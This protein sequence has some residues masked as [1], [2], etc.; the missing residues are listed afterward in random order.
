MTRNR[1]KY[2]TNFLIKTVASSALLWYTIVINGRLR[3]R[4][5]TWKDV[6]FKMARGMLL[7]GVDE[8]ELRP[9]PKPEKPKTP[10]GK[11]ENFWFYHKWH[12]LIGLAIAAVVTFCV[13][14]VVTKVHP[15]Y[16]GA[17]ITAD[18]VLYEHKYELDKALL[19]YADDV[20]ED[21]KLRM[22]VELL[23]IG[24]E[25]DAPSELTA[26]YLTKMRV[27]MADDTTKL[28]IVDKET[29]DSLGMDYHDHGLEFYAPLDVDA[30]GYNAEYHYWDWYGSEWQQSEWGQQFP[31]H[32]YFGVR[33]YLSD[34][35]KEREVK[36]FEATKAFLENLIKQTPPETTAVPVE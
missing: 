22:G 34:E 25:D 31:E 8:E 24:G 20:N 32:L 3:K 2:K 19:S 4:R 18:S 14:D 35:P 29:F 26:T 17:I 9:D 23:P 5:T 10:K 6:K 11:W 16:D 15:D 28:V 36:A 12:V 13:V 7:A 21:G 1:R 30:P 33:P 27:L